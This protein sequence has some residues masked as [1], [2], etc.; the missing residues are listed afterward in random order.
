M[1]YGNENV[2]WLSLLDAVYLLNVKMGE[3]AARDMIISRIIYERLSMKARLVVDEADKGEVIFNPSL[4]TEDFALRS[5]RMQDYR[6]WYRRADDIGNSL[7]EVPRGFFSKEEGWIIDLA[8]TS[9]LNGNL[10]ARR[11]C[12]FRTRL[13]KLRVTLPGYNDPAPEGALSR[14]IVTGF[15][16]Q[17]EQIENI[18]QPFAKEPIQDEPE[19]VLQTERRLLKFVEYEIIQLMNSNKMGETFGYLEGP[20][21]KIGITNYLCDN[22]RK[23]NGDLYARSYLANRAASLLRVWRSRSRHPELTCHRPSANMRTN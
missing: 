7:I 11:P 3:Q 17:R 2:E 4:Y 5:W 20:N 15:R 19:A 18:I 21:L 22:A 13:G 10:V 6:S 1:A 12:K 23:A 14:R 8:N 16:L 9:W